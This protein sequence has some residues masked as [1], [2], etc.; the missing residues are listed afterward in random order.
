[1]L[2]FWSVCFVLVERLDV[3]EE[4]LQ[5]AE[6]RPMLLGPKGLKGE[7]GDRGIEVTC[8]SFDCPQSIIKKNIFFW[9]I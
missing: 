2:I 7:I 1:M 9:Q 6:K 5:A 3:M 8:F 4:R